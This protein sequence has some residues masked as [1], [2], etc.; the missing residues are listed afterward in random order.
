[1]QSTAKNNKA[2]KAVLLFILVL[3]VCLCGYGY[4]RAVT[5]YLKNL[6]AYD[7]APLTAERLLQ[8]DITDTDKLM[9]VAH[10]DDETIWGGGHLY[11]KGYLVLCITNG[12]NEVRKKEFENAVK[13]SGNIPLILEY[14]D[15]VWGER[16]DWDNV[17]EQIEEDISLVMSAKDWQLI[18]T[19]NPD[20]EYGHIHHKMTSALTRSAYS[21]AA[22]ACPLY[23][24]GRY[25][26]AKDIGAVK[27]SLTP[28]DD[29]RLAFKNGLSEEYSSQAAVF[30]KLA[31]MMPYE[32]WTEYDSYE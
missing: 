25:Y 4:Y 26:K 24:F 28:V 30:D 9:I 8:A 6:R 11:D 17:R 22:P 10:P 23:C 3:F 16:D 20:G 19:H 14:P 13:R 7:V 29:E 31:H 1:M 12:R 2:K 21:K 15:K 18:V 27:G 5:G 32:Q